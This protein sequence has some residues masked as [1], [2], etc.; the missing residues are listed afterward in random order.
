MI[1]KRNNAPNCFVIA[2]I[3]AHLVLGNFIN[4]I[5]SKNIN[6]SHVTSFFYIF[7][8]VFYRFDGMARFIIHVRIESLMGLEN[9]EQSNEYQFR[10]LV[11]LVLQL[12]IFRFLQSITDDTGDNHNSL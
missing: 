3:D 6:H 2:N 5:L 4:G 11:D 1:R 12:L 7:A 8:T 10:Y 9:R